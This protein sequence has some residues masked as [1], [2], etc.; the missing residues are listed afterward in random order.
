VS[1]C[2]PEDGQRGPGAC[3]LARAR[4]LREH[5]VARVAERVERS[6]AAG[7]VARD[8]EARAAAQR[9]DERSPR[10]QQLTR[11][12]ALELEHRPQPGREGPGRQVAALDTVPAAVLARQVDAAGERVLAHVL[13]VLDDL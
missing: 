3:R 11:A 13:H 9:G 5:V 10:A 4:R 6:D 2:A 7:D 8:G 1:P 12:V